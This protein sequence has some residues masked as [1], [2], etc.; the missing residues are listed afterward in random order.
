[1]IVNTLCKDNTFNILLLETFEEETAPSNLILYF[2]DV[3]ESSSAFALFSKSYDEYLSTNDKSKENKYAKDIFD[4][5]KLFLIKSSNKQSKK[6]L[7][8][9]NENF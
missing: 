9:K 1:M 8:G 6:N 2:N 3:M 7:G 4:T 5:I